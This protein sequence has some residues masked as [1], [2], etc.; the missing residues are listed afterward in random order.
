MAWV[1]RYPREPNGEQSHMNLPR[2]PFSAEGD[3]ESK[4]NYIISALWCAIIVIP[5]TNWVAPEMI[6]YDMAFIWNTHGTSW[7][8][9]LTVGIPIFAWG[10]GVT[11]VLKF[12]KPGYTRADRMQ[13]ASA[14]NIFVGGTLI[15]AWAG[16]TEELAFRWL[17]FCGAFL[18]IFIANWLFF[19]CLG[20]GIAEWFYLT[21]FGPIANFTTGGYLEPWLFHESGWMAGA[22]LLASNQFFRDGHKY[23]GF[24]GWVNSWFLGMFFFY[25]M[26]N[27]G[28]L[29]AIVVHFAYDWIIFTTA[30]CFRFLDSIV[31]RIRRRSSNGY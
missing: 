20:F 30:A 13:R 6:P 10:F 11:F 1:A 31:E 26:F 12:L 25:V 9:W 2:L 18:G 16:I 17:S 27:Y 24:F 29:A 4:R 21:I 8:D 19:D 5:F 15:S 7:I 23:Q 22:A 28:L 14:S 3:D